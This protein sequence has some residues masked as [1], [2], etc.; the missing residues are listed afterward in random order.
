MIGVVVI[1]ANGFFPFLSPHFAASVLD[2]LLG[3]VLGAGFLWCMSEGYFRLRGK[4][5]M[6]LGDVKLLMLVGAFFGVPGAFF[7]IFL[8]SIF[9][10]VIGILCILL[11]GKKFSQHIPF[12]PYLAAGTLWYLFFL[13]PT[14]PVVEMMRVALLDS[15]AFS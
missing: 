3:I 4:V 13:D 10:S 11:G 9:G 12:G 5:G 7:T 6:G 8:G 14:S 2:A 1:I 15:G